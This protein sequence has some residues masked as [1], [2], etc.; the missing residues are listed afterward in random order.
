M[1]KFLAVLGVVT[2]AMI[3]APSA[4]AAITDAFDG[5]V[6]CGDVTTEGNVSTSLGQRWCGTSRPLPTNQK[7]DDISSVTTPALPTTRS[8]VESFDGVPIDVNVAF[9][10]TGGDGPYP[11]VMMF[12]GYGGQRMSFKSM[13]R[14]L[15][16]GYAVYSQ[17]NRGFHESCG[18]AGAKAADADCL[19][20][21]FVRLNDTRY[22][23]RDAQLFA[24]MLVDDGLVDPTKIAA[25]GGSYGGGMSMALGALKDRVM[26]PNDSLVPWESPDG[27][28]MSLALALP[29]IPWTDL[30]YSLVPN[31]SNFDYIKD[32]SY[33]GRFGVMKQSYVNGLY[34][35]GALAPGYY[36][37]P[38]VQPSADLT[39]WLAYMNLGEPYDG[40]AQAEAILDEIQT[41]H[42]SYYIPHDT[43]PAPMLISSGFTDDLFP[44]NEA[45][46]YYNRTRAQFAN[47]KIGLFFGSFGHPR[48]QN[49][50]G[51]GS[52]TAA[53]QTEENTWMDHYLGGVG[54]EPTPDVTAWTQGCPSSE[55]VAYDSPDWASSASGEIRLEGGDAE[56]TISP[57]G[58]DRAVGTT[59]NPQ[60]AGG[61]ADAC[62][63]PPGAKEPG[64]ANYE[65]DPAPAAGFTIMGS[66]T[67]VAKIQQA[68]NNSQIASRLVDVSPDGTTKTLIDR[69][70]WR[71]ANSGFQVFQLNANG[72]EV[73][74]GHVVR[75]ELLPMDA[76]VADQATGALS[77]Y[78]RPSNGQQPATISYMDLRIPVIEAPGAL[79]GL[80]KAP[81]PKVL[82][83]RPG[84][85]LAK[86]FEAIGSTTLD[87]YT[88]DTDPCPAGTSGTTPPDCVEDTC[89]AGQVGTPPDCQ[90]HVLP[91][92]MPKVTGKVIVKGKILK[93]KIKCGSDAYSCE[94]IKL[95]FKAAPKKARKSKRSRKVRGRGIAKGKGLTAEPGQT[96]KVKLKLTRN[97]RKY[98]KNRKFRKHGKKRM[99]RGPRSLR[100]KVLVNGKRAGYKKVKRVG[101]VK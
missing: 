71:P 43:A 41:H 72:W 27:T 95:A 10:S 91:Q 28:S 24:G 23:V 85:E 78:G 75:L 30:S 83:D 50:S 70:L 87:D 17:T 56:Q 73:K 64:T 60:S 37:A 11:L 2:A 55:E 68:G 34:A 25:V 39:G 100:A 81:A 82:P 80:V 4:N 9:P 44:A 12:H 74:A 96:V 20:K 19:T 18:S 76:G 53:L 93:A 5:A 84:V 58:G 36:T 52:V 8:T 90:P 35:A 32:A 31:G 69:A 67:V 13:Q 63:T 51:A 26:M 89:P 97:A 33:Y 66:P 48:G 77:N 54:A 38:G 98:F 57:T 88:Q 15:D 40:D 1:R 59:L 42:S 45:T 47:S 92:S 79:G 62:A 49:R 21:G 65:L 6:S 94:K 29:N 99:K 22:E 86:G 46:R 7:G 3:F 14:W 61:A 101:R 16:K